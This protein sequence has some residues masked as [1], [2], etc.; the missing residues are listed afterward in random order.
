MKPSAVVRSLHHER[1]D[2]DVRLT[3]SGELCAS[4]EPENVGLVVDRSG[5]VAVPAPTKSVGKATTVRQG[6]SIPYWDVRGRLAGVVAGPEK[7]GTLSEAFPVL[8]E[9][10]NRHL[11]CPLAYRDDQSRR[12]HFVGRDCIRVKVRRT[13]QPMLSVVPTHIRARRRRKFGPAAQRDRC[14][15]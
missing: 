6:H 3:V 14:S 11:S 2:G 5:F 1:R 8:G 10:E 13:G 9:N 15:N 4:L 7:G 12:R